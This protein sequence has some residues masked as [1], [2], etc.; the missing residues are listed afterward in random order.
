MVA[1]TAEDA[2]A[3]GI[4]VSDKDFTHRIQTANAQRGW[5]PS[6]WTDRVTIGD[7]TIRDVR[8]VVSESGAMTVSLL[9]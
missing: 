2:D 4:F 3:A 9:A 7:I 6:S 8:G 5:H 1:L